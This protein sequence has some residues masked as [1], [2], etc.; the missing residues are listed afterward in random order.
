MVTDIHDK[1]S[2]QLS[3]IMH[4][5][6]V[7]NMLLKMQNDGL[8]KSLINEK[9]KRK[10]GKP[11]LLNFD[12]RKE[13]GAVF[14]SPNKIQQARNRQTAKDKQAEAN[15]MQKEEGKALREAKKM[16][17]QEAMETREIAKAL[18]KKKEKL[19]EH[20]Q[21]RVQKEDDALAKLA[22]Q[23]PQIHLYNG[24]QDGRDRVGY[25]KNQENKVIE[26]ADVLV[27]E[28][29]KIIRNAQGREIR[30]PQRFRPIKT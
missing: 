10:C 3:N 19:R 13:G 20:A 4:A 8:K 18:K 9:K 28:E 26:G 29:A 23:Q 5:L 24:G 7:E 14:F 6:S 17:K 16:E 2:Q 27:I 15:R 30:L 21:K 11:L 1:R 12:T 22:N 25:G